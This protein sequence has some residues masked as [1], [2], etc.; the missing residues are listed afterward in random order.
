MASRVR[1]SCVLA[2]VVT[3]CGLA[4]GGRDVHAGAIIAKKGTTT[5]VG[6]PRFDYDFEIDLV[7]G[8]TLAFGGF[9]TVYDIPSLELPI[10]TFQPNAFWGS[11]VQNVGITPPGTPP[12]GDPPVTDNPNIPNV[13]WVYHG[14]AIVNNT[15]SDMDLGT[16]VVGETVSLT[17]PPDPRLLFVGSLDGVT[18][19]NSGFVQVNAVPEPSSVVLLL[20]GVVALSLFWRHS[21][22]L[23]QRRKVAKPA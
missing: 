1:S 9:I 3:L 21:K 4:G 14:P 12:P 2:V 7:A 18:L 8:S 20:T 6:D 16:F 17:S 19:S 11:E 5:P 10:L 13:T 23:T 22:A 15:T